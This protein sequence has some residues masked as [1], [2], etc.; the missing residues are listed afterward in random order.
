MSRRLI[1]GL[2]ALFLAATVAGF[3]PT[4]RAIGAPPLAATG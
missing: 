3:M 1:A 2:I 4:Q